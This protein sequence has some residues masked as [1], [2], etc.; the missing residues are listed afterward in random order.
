[1]KLTQW[2]GRDLDGTS[3]PLH[4]PII[5]AQTLTSP[6]Q[7][8][9]AHIWDI[10]ASF[11]VLDKTPGQINLLYMDEKMK[12]N[13][14]LTNGLPASTLMYCSYCGCLH[15]VFLFNE[16]LLSISRVCS[17]LVLPPK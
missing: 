10:L 1:M 16:G 4:S 15:T 3:I 17:V 12:T 2:N 8:G 5:T 14:S 11:L 6:G 13:C 7:D 9:S